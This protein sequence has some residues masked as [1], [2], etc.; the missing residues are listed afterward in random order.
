MEV[1]DRRSVLLVVEGEN[2]LD[3]QQ[4]CTL[5][6]NKTTSTYTHTMGL[7]VLREDL[8]RLEEKLHEKRIRLMHTWRYQ[9][10]SF[11]NTAAHNH[12]CDVIQVPTLLHVEH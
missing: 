1:W 9:H 11:P 3:Q 10:T 8:D 7:G 6:K 12:A 4:A 5:T 2:K